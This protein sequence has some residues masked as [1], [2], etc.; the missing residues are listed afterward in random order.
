[1]SDWAPRIGFEGRADLGVSI[2]TAAIL[3]DVEDRLFPRQ[4]TQL[5]RHGDAL[6]L[7]GAAALG[8]LAAATS[9]LAV[10]I[11]LTLIFHFQPT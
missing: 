7:A 3:I 4:P 9:T 6:R 2:S 11:V 8:C 5:Q 1:M 10:Y